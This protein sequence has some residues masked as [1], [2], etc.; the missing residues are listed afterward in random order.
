MTASQVP[1]KVWTAYLRD[2]PSDAERTAA[3]AEFRAAAERYQKGVLS[4]QAATARRERAQGNKAQLAERLAG[5]L[6]FGSLYTTC[7][8]A[9]AKALA[10][11][12]DELA[13]GR[14]LATSDLAGKWAP[15]PGHS[16]DRELKLAEAIALEMQCAD[17]QVRPR[18]GNW[19][20]GVGWR[21]VSRCVKRPR[22]CGFLSQRSRLLSEGLA[23][24]ECS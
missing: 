12:R 3:K 1:R 11:D 16:A 8:G 17:N 2:L 9:F 20:N 24:D 18:R 7:V 10:R 5:D 4:L 21:G 23:A 15:T 13:A 19:G 22:V 6:R 14:A